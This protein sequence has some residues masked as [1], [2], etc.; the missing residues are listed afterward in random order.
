MYIL[1]YNYTYVLYI[2]IHIYIKGIHTYVYMWIIYGPGNHF[3]CICVCVCV[4]VLSVSSLYNLSIVNTDCLGIIDWIKTHNL[5]LEGKKMKA[6]VVQ[7]CPTLWHIMD[8]SPPGS[9][10]HGVLHA[11]YWNALPFSTPGDLP[12][13][14][15]ELSHFIYF[16]WWTFWGLQAQEAA[17]QIA[18]RDGFEEVGEEPGYIGVLATKTR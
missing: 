16:I 10:V 17:S 9:S 2:H 18:L 8:C 1:M 11:R 6:L 5:K 12:H 3:M 13:P 14:G 15:I 7:L 4:C